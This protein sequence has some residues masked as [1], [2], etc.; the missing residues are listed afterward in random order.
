MIT[1][2]ELWNFSTDKIETSSGAVLVEN[3][4]L[5]MGVL[6]DRQ[7]L[8]WDALTGKQ[9]WQGEQTT[10][11]WGDFWSYS[12]ES[13]Y[14]M[15]YSGTY[16]ALY[17]FNWTNG[18]IVWKFEAPADPYETPYTD[19]NGS[20]VYSWHSSLYVADGKIFTYNS[21]HTPSE[22]ITRGWKWFAINATTGEE[23]WNLPGSGCR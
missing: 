15:I 20:T 13:A 4:K 5:A 6:E 9:L 17:A 14:G 16:E 7:W 1:G 18:K 3:G 10:N 23:I 21:E 12:S 2:Q 11:P 8:C 22:P 19:Q